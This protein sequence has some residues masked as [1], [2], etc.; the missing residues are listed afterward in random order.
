VGD[1]ALTIA[2]DWARP[3]AGLLAALARAGASQVS[4]ATGGRG[5]LDG[6]IRHLVGKLRVLGPALPVWTA[7]GDN[8]A[9]YAALS[10]L[11]PGDV[12]V[13][14]SGAHHDCALVGDHM[15]RLLHNAGAAG[16]VTDG[17]VRDLEGLREIGMPVYAR[18][19][20]PRAPHKS[21]PGT[22]G[23]PVSLGGVLVCAG[24][25]VVADE[26]GVVVLPRDAFDSIVTRLDA[27]CAREAQTDARARAGATE[28]PDF[29]AL[30]D[31][32]GVRWLS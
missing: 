12:L 29:K 2:R 1:P 30:L 21:G 4:D 27:L 22:V 20:S 25:I 15:G 5:A 23:L 24:D 31:R 14:A 7:P 6:R 28:P 11:R 16:V 13:L 18:G 32:A 9:P 8:L 10:V 17:R 26:D 3:D 19:I